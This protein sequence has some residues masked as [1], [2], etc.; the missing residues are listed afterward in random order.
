MCIGRKNEKFLI[1]F[2]K[3]L[4]KNEVL[5]VKSLIILS[6]HLKYTPLFL[7]FELCSSGF[8]LSFNLTFLVYVIIYKKYTD[9]Q[10]IERVNLVK[11]I[12]NKN[13]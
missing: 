3:V 1:K 9:K 4:S 2:F 10:I 6:N 8:T 7:G 13:L 11:V 12:N 5:S